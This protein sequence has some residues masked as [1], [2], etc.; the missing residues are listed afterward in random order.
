MSQNLQ[1]NNNTAASRHCEGGTTDAIQRKK[2]LVWIASFL[3]M[4]SFMLVSCTKEIEFKGEHTDS[5]LVINSIMEPGKP[6]KAYISKSIFFLNNNADMVAPDDL[7]ATLYV[8]GNLIGEMTRQPDTIWEGYEYVDMDSMMPVYKIVPAFVNDYRPNMGDVIKITATANGFDE[9]EGTS[10]PLPNNVECS[11]S[12]CDLLVWEANEFSDSLKSITAIFDVN[13]EIRD[14]NP[15]QLDYFR[16][17]NER[18]DYSYGDGRNAFTFFLSYDDPVFGGSADNDLID[19]S[20][21]TRAEG[22]FTDQLFDGRSYTVKLLLYAYLYT[23]GTVDPSF[24][25]A[26]ICVEHL[27]KEYYYYLN[28]CDQGDEITQFFS[29]PAQTYTNVTNGYGIV[30][31]RIVDTIRFPLPIEEP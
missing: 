14:P 28:T 9:A 30:G 3:A 18:N 1:N 15:G 20:F 7:M 23:D 31:G 10:N 25:N 12:K 24:F 4:T 5:K 8:N 13:I 11:I 16:L 21:D 19:I 29:E 22:V 2:P 17:S 27:S 6:V 26:P